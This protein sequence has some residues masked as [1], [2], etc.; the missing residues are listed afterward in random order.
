MNRILAGGNAL[1]ALCLTRSG[2]SDAF[3]VLLDYLI[4]SRQHVRRDRETDLL[5]GFQVDDEFES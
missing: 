1:K 3:S 5:R 4:R 2:V